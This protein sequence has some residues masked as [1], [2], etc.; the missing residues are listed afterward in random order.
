MVSQ[1]HRRQWQVRQFSRERTCNSVSVGTSK[2][3]W[4]GKGKITE[5]VMIIVFYIQTKNCLVKYRKEGGRKQGRKEGKLNHEVFL[6]LNYHIVSLFKMFLK[7]KEVFSGKIF[8]SIIIAIRKTLNSCN[9]YNITHP[10]ASKIHTRN[11]HWI[12]SAAW[13]SS[14]GITYR[15]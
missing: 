13:P 6:S 14:A 15:N 3:I 4:L 8:S 10:V 7:D 1:V 9:S 5:T 12:A 2:L 11:E